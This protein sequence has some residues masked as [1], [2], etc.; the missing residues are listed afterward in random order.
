MRTIKLGEAFV[1]HFPVFE[2]DQ[3]TKRSGVAVFSTAVWHDGVV[4]AVP[5]TVAEIGATGEY[6][7]TIT[8]TAVGAWGVEVYVPVSG[9]R[10]GEDVTVEQ[11]QVAWGFSAADDEV[12]I[13]FS[14]WADLDGQTI[15]DLDSLAAVIR[16]QAGT[17]EIDLGTE[18]VP[19]ARG[20]YRF[21]T[22]SGWVPSGD[23]YYLSVTATRDIV[24][25]TGSLG[26]NKV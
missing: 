16:N 4:S 11:Q 19:D 6:T 8:P 26:F 20:V 25:W 15:L 24:I 13:S 12:E 5:A 17:V 9:D 22:T 18:T 2:A 7:V 14:V 3:V 23:E 1:A 21:A 10:W